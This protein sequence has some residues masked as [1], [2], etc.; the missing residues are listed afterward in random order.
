MLQISV[1]ADGAPGHQH[2]V[3]LAHSLVELCRK[4][5]ISQTEV[6]EIV[7]LWENL[8]DAEKGPVLY[9]PR[10]RVQLAKGRFKRSSRRSATWPDTSR[11]VEAIFIRLCI[12]HPHCKRMMG[13]LVTRWSLV[14]RDYNT[15]RDVVVLH[16]DLMTRTTLQLFVVN[17]AT[18]SQW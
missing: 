18:L 2:V 9:P 10:Y 5:Y 7:G 16:P 3:R 11:L 1:G 13:C 8:P 4:G 15:I 12:L 6:E 17:Q 14:L